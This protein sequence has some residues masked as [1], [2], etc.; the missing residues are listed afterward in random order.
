MRLPSLWTNYNF[1]AVHHEVG[2]EPQEPSVG[3][4]RRHAFECVAALACS[5]LRCSKSSN[6]AHGHAETFIGT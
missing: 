6:V 3:P 4:G 2:S 5:Y 1:R